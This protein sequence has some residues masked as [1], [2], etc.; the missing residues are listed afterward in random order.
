VREVNL[1]QQDE[2][3]GIKMV[4]KKTAV[5][6]VVL[7]VA[8]LSYFNMEAQK[9]PRVLRSYIET[10]RFYSIEAQE[11]PY[12][13]EHNNIEEY[14]GRS[15]LMTKEA[16]FLEFVQFVLNKVEEPWYTGRFPPKVY[17]FSERGDC[18]LYFKDSYLGRNPGKPG[19]TEE[20]T[21]TVLW[22][23]K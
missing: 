1:N 16:L 14:V 2:A 13:G 21:V 18:G 17:W 20:V 11:G 12:P 19:E 5:I 23:P 3:E 6:A 8:G 4:D 15:P 22:K 10:L 7:L 9:P